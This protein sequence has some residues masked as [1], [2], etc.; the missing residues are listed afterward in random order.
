MNT[1]A[2]WPTNRYGTS[3][4][5][6]L[7]F[8]DWCDEQIVDEAI[9]TIDPLKITSHIQPVIVVGPA[10]VEHMSMQQFA[11]IVREDD[12]RYSAVDARPDLKAK[13]AEIEKDCDQSTGYFVLGLARLDLAD[14]PTYQ[15]LLAGFEDSRGRFALW[16]PNIELDDS[17]S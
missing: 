10:E 4:R 8:F 13:C 2:S 7:V 14:E 15:A 12:D 6:A 1:A 9:E 17:N 3:W 11:E 5:H 16:M